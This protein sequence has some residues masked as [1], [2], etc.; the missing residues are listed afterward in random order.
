MPEAFAPAVGHRFAGRFELQALLRGSGPARVF[1]ASDGGARPL[2]LVLFDPSACTPGAWSGLLRV[3]HAASEARL[4]GIEPL[5]NIP[6]TPPDPPFCLADPPVGWSFDRLRQG[7]P[8]AWQKQAAPPWERAL[9]LGERAAAILGAAHTALGVPHRALTAQ[10]LVVTEA[11][12][13]LIL[14]FGVGELEPSAGRP[15]DCGYRAPEQASSRGDVRSD[16]F[17]L[18]SVLFEL[19]AGE[20]PSPRMPARLRSLVPG[21]PQA[22]DELFAEALAVE[23]WQ[24]YADMGELREALRDVLGLGPAPAASSSAPV[25]QVMPPPAEAATASEVD[26]SRSDLPVLPGSPSTPAPVTAGPSLGRSSLG[27]PVA[28]P[29]PELRTSGPS[30]VSAPPGGVAASTPARSMVS[31]APGGATTMELPSRSSVSTA[32]GGATT[33]ELPSR[34]IVS[35]APGGATTMELPSRSSVSTPPAPESTMELPARSIEST[36]PGPESTME[37]PSPA[38]SIVS[39]PPGG[40]S[41]TELPSPA[42]TI[43]S[44]SPE[45]IAREQ[46][47]SGLA[48]SSVSPTPRRG[49]V[50]PSLESSGSPSPARPSAFPTPRGPLLPPLELSGSSGP[51][52]SNAT[53]PRRGSLLPPVEP[54]AVT[55]MPTRP[56][57]SVDPSA[58]TSASNR[59][60]IDWT[61]PRPGTPQPESPRPLRY[62][63]LVQPDADETL[64][65][66]AASDRDDPPAARTETLPE[67]F[68]QAARTEVWP[69]SFAQ[70][71]APAAKTEVWPQSF[72]Q[73]AAPAAKTELVLPSFAQAAKTESV[74]QP[75][76]R[77]RSTG[78]APAAR[79][80]IF[81]ASRPERTEILQGDVALPAARSER[82]ELLSAGPSVVEPPQLG[83]AVA[84]PSAA[85]PRP[86]QP[87]STPNAARQPAPRAASPANSSGPPIKLL[88]IT[89]NA[90]LLVVI[91]L[92]LAL[93]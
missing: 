58:S 66:E 33:M 85:V 89:V 83:R 71:A 15:D 40:E 64:V 1:T 2:V 60:E 31:A 63:K 70:E 17:S 84:D 25:V 91:V 41:T 26:L 68:V 9:R 28:A 51:A 19:I 32:P 59:T 88:L 29:T 3:V 36:P 49:P 22:V 42:R 8:P 86:A 30:I 77:L 61:R 44:A 20:R 27:S 78:D 62:S 50:L 56:A 92:V 43:A 6:T 69:Q 21:V 57:A 79:T 52:R 37:L 23:P 65:P 55:P 73:A 75:M 35:T 48:R 11:D 16:V 93:R 5:R 81:V 7:G 53:T 10:R 46:A 67:S 38:R 54:L 14:D 34:S 4:V 24:R 87:R 72:A 12:E 18:A 90:V 74:P 39:A 45:A 13:L 47:A 76:A 82:T 80:E